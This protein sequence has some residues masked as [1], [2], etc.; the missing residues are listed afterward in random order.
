MDVDCEQVPRAKFDLMGYSVRTTEWRFTEWRMWDGVT[1]QARWDLPA[2]ATELY[3][4]R[5][6]SA[7]IFSTETVNLAADPKYEPIR[8]MLQAQL[9]EAFDA[10][11]PPTPAPPACEATLRSLCKAEMTVAWKCVQCAKSHSDQL[12]AAG[13]T[14]DLVQ[15]ICVPAE[16]V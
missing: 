10:P 14:A 8:K 1:L 4:H 11:A 12:S 3:D 9:R 13:C 15:A 16:L 7:D 5:T 6:P 2:N